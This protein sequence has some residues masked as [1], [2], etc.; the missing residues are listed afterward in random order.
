MSL[1][2]KTEFNGGLIDALVEKLENPQPLLDRIGQHLV[3]TTQARIRTTKT[4]P[5][6]RPWAPW[7]EATRNARAKDG[8][9]VFGLLYKSGSLFNSINYRVAGDSVTVSSD[10]TLAPYAGYLQNGTPRMPARP[11]LGISEGDVDAVRSFI[12]RHIGQTR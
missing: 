12:A 5:D 8:S 2:V 3:A 6:D 1:V 9:T 10:P 7:A 4:G 11:F